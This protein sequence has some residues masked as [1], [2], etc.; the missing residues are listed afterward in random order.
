MAFVSK[1]CRP[2]SLN[3]E[4]SLSRNTKHGLA[5]TEVRVHT[6]GVD[7]FTIFWRLMHTFWWWR[8]G[9]MVI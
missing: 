5:N 7:I 4:M 3:V 6:S 9:I 8:P 1:V 2:Q